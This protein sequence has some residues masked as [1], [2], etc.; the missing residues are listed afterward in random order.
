MCVKSRYEFINMV[1]FGVGVMVRVKVMFI[2]VFH[3]KLDY[4]HLQVVLSLRVNLLKVRI[5]DLRF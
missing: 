5:R 2:L 3:N 1:T 4:G